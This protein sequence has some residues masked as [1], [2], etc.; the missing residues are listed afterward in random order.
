MVLE[1]VYVGDWFSWG[2]D[3]LKIS[4]GLDSLKIGSV[5]DWIIWRLDLI[6]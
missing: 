2:L 4:R 3:Y 1:I 6:F 5:G